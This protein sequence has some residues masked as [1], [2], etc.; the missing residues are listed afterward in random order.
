MLKNLLISDFNIQTPPL[1]LKLI[2]YKIG[3]HFLELSGS[4]EYEGRLDEVP[5]IFSLMKPLDGAIEAFNKLSELYDIYILSTA[6][7]ENSTVWSDKNEWVKKHLGPAARKRLIVSHN[8]HLNRGDYLIDDRTVN[9]A[10]EFQGEHIH[11]GQ[12]KFPDWKSVLDYLL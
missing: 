5:G 3:S 11:F 8:K 1:S 4:K 9:G 7:L 2:L 6:P 12:E 10:G